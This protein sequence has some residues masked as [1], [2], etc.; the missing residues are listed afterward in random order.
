MTRLASAV[1]TRLAWRRRGAARAPGLLA[2]RRSAFGGS[3]L[4]RPYRRGDVACACAARDPRTPLRAR[5][6]SACR[7]RLPPGKTSAPGAAVARWVRSRAVQ[8]SPRPRCSSTEKWSPF[9]VAVALH[10]R[11]SNGKH[12]G[13]DLDNQR[14]APV[15]LDQ[16]GQA[17]AH[18]HFRSSADVGEKIT[19]DR[20]FSDLLVMERLTSAAEYLQRCFRKSHRAFS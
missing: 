6:G 4:R 7:R 3:R 13:L 18:G 2:R 17:R 11:F 16:G 9:A 1:V 12:A 8:Q 10:E 5:R 15:L 14:L 20:E 19:R